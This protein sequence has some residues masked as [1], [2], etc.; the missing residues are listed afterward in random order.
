MRPPRTVIVTCAALALLGGALLVAAT[1]GSARPAGKARLTLHG[2]FDPPTDSG[3][4]AVHVRPHT[5]PA[6]QVNIADAP[7]Q[8]D[9]GTIA[10]LPARLRGEIKRNGEFRIAKYFPPD[11]GYDV[12]RYYDLQGRLVNHRLAK[13]TYTVLFVSFEPFAPSCS[14]A[15]PLPWH[16][17]R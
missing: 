7:L 11:P 17:R 4:I 8:C 1:A 14:T 5:H 13:G 10:R 6:L 3:T 15:Y 16:A 2:Q 12:R 9:D